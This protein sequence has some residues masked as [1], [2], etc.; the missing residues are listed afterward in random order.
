M[1]WWRRRHGDMEKGLCTIASWDEFKRELNRQ[2]YPENAAHEARA[3]LRRLSHKG[4]IRE[5]V[6]EFVETLL[7][8]PDYPDAEALF[9]FTD[10]LQTWAR[11]EIE[12][13]GARDLATAIS[14]AESLVEFQR[15]ERSRTSPHKDRS[16][17]GDS[18]GKDRSSKPK[19]VHPRSQRE[20]RGMQCPPLSCFL[21]D[22]PHR[23]R[24]CPKKSKLSALVEEREKAPFQPREATMGSLQLS[25]L[26]VQEKGTVSVEKGRPF[27]QIQVGG[28]KLRALLDTGASHNF[29]TVEEAKRLG[30]PYEREMGWLKAV[31]ST[32][33]LIHGV[34]RDTK[35]RIGNWHGTLD[36]FIVSMDDS[37]CILGVD[38]VDRAKAIP[39]LFANSMCITEGGGTCVVP[40]LRGKASNTLA[41][42]HVEMHDPSSAAQGE[43]QHG[44]GGGTPKKDP[45]ECKR[46]HTPKLQKGQPP[47]E[48]VDCARG[49]AVARS[50]REESS[51]RQEGPRRHRSRKSRR[52]CKAEGRAGALSHRDEGGTAGAQQEK[53][54]SNTA[55]HAGRHGRKSKRR[56]RRA[57]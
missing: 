32:P 50:P 3:R 38:F 16:E 52:K 55:V 29:L 19:E 40:L 13:R 7:E 54:R 37:P 46:R 39:M 41:T 48:K 45:K 10:G 25:A 22:G 12:R 33:N 57:D 24:E 15:S 34:A 18:E 42:M 21:C 8:I 35:V 6:K 49:N 53:A 14:I 2:F 36:F 1:V 23:A 9:A 26:K 44:K 4:S 11:M 20:D 31:N 47:R 30:I 51:P 28:Q 43:K 27:V 56:G 5:Y 17:G